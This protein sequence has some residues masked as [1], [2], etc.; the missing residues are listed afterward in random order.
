[1]LAGDPK[2]LGPVIHSNLAGKRGLRLSLLERLASSPAYAAAE[3][4]AHAAAGLIVK[5]VCNYRYAYNGNMRR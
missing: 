5:L 3:T 4:G 2:Q 1:M